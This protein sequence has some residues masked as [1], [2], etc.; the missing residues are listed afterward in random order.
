MRILITGGY[1]F[2]GARLAKWFFDEGHEI[3]L[4]TRQHDT[5]PSWLSE[6]K[7]YKINW[8]DS[9][10]IDKICINVDMIIHAAGMNASDCIEDPVAAL[11]FNGLITAKLLRSALNKGVK[12]FIYISTFHIYDR[13]LVG[14]INEDYLPQN[15]NPYA[16][17]HRAGEDIIRYAHEK[18]EID[19]VV[20]RLSNA[21]GT[22]MHK[23]T[24][25]WM[26]LI[27][28]LCRQ[29]VKTKTMLLSTYGT[30]YR[31]F[32]PMREVCRAIGHLSLLPRKTLGNGLFN[33]GSGSSCTVWEM[34]S[35][36]QKV[37]TEFFD[38]NTK[39]VRNQ[40]VAGKERYKLFEYQIDKLKNTNFNMNINYQNE[41]I[42]LLNFCK[43]VF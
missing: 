6:A 1:G 27:Q 30:Q 9:T 22:P 21:F 35:L 5:S 43:K 25:C 23:D 19:G 41:L 36:V 40:Q 14:K 10:N 42:E 29:A 7:V 3:F 8:D 33:L 39:L 11:S 13:L 4:T 18:N 24:N 26:L 16:T 38:I 37:C 31:D 15:M 28:D 32:I 12:R 34:A 20:I 17:S 2:I